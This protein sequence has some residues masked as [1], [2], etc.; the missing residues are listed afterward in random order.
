[1]KCKNCKKDF[2]PTHHFQ[3]YCSKECAYLKKLQRCRKQWA[4]KKNQYRTSF[5]LN[6]LE[7]QGYKITREE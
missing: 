5:C 1:M 2:K 7:K 3:R 4:T 6:Y